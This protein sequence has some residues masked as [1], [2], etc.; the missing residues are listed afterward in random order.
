MRAQL[1]SCEQWGCFIPERH[2]EAIESPVDSREQRSF[3]PERHQEANER[4]WIAA[5]NE[6]VLHIRDIRTRKRS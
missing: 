3:I 5:N 6:V 1:D 2:K 4:S